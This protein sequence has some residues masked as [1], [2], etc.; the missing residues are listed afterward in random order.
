[1]E[2]IYNYITE[3]TLNPVIIA[4]ICLLYNHITL[5]FTLIYDDAK[6]AQQTIVSYL[7]NREELHQ[8]PNKSAINCSLFMEILTWLEPGLKN[9]SKTPIA[10]HV[11]VRTGVDNRII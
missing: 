7:D 9:L 6:H 11:N 5:L 2:N 1:L 10:L 4:N 8:N 3:Y